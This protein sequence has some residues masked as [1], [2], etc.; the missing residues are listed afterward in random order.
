MIH[1]S[2]IST[3]F[4][5]DFLSSLLPLFKWGDDTYGKG[6]STARKFYIFPFLNAQNSTHRRAVLIEYI[7]YN[8]LQTFLPPLRAINLISLNN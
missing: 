6:G 1:G 5:N 2:V 8:K 4:A 7:M 3:H